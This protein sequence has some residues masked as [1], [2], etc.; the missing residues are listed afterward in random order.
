[1]ATTTVSDSSPTVPVPPPTAARIISTSLLLHLYRGGWRGL[2]KTR[3]KVR[4]S[5]NTEPTARREQR[6]GGATCV[7]AAD[8]LLN[9]RHTACWSAAR[10]AEHGRSSVLQIKRS[11]IVCTVRGCS[12]RCS[13]K[14]VLASRDHRR[15]GLCV[16]KTERSPRLAPMCREM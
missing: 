13:R 8:N 2:V 5:V 6:R 4:R 14:N 15:A 3:V 11:S 7:A 9:R 1:V 12:T 10:M 16:W